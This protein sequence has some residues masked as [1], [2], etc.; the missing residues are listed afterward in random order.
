MN[1]HQSA[2]FLRPLSG[3]FTI[4]LAPILPAA[5]VNPGMRLLLMEV[6]QNEGLVPRTT[7]DAPDRESPA[8]LW[9]RAGAEP[10]ASGNF[11]PRVK[12]DTDNPL[13]AT[14][15]GPVPIKMVHVDRAVALQPIAGPTKTGYTC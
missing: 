9:G 4:A 2:A 7:F 14:L 10:F 6:Y 3:L 8:G 5:C 12:P 11:T 13:P 1:D 15:L